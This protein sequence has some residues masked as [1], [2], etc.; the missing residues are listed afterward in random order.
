MTH[1]SV[2]GQIWRRAMVTRIVEETP[3]CRS[4]ELEV[5]EA[6]SVQPGQY[7]ALAVTIEGVRYVRCYSFSHVAA[8]GEP[9]TITVKRQHGGIVSTW[10]NDDCR[11]NETI[12]VGKP[13][14]DF[15]VRP[16]TAPLLFLAAGSGITPIFAMLRSALIESDRRVSLLYVNRGAS[17]VIFAAQLDRLRHEFP[18]RFTVHHALT[19]QSRAQLDTML[20]KTIAETRFA[21]IYLCGPAGFMR[22]CERIA[23]DLGIAPERIFS[24]SF[25]AEEAEAPAGRP[26]SVIVERSGSTKV[27]VQT[28]VGAT[29]LSALLQSGEPQ[30]G[31]CGGQASCGT[32]RISIDAAWN[33]TFAPASRSERRL[34]D[35][36]P[37]PT[38][39]HRLACQ[40]RLA[41][42][43]ANLV[44]ACAPLQ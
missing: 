43:H 6:S 14:G 39:A 36:L 16:G 33:D 25:L 24:E 12:E 44:F 4:F 11:L 2:G 27:A 21:D 41:E 5:E 18:N 38:S 20:S 26:I 9:P 19:A 7:S 30:V 31:I 32:C 42:A 28:R 17:E 1:T 40:V 34:L 3:A 22:T 10:F 29:A 37:N 15:V 8:L 35:V 23:A 13:A